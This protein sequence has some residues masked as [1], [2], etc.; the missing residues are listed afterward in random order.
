MQCHFLVS[1]GVE[2]PIENVRT[3]TV[4]SPQAPNSTTNWWR[5]YSIYPKLVGNNVKGSYSW[6]TLISF[7][8]S[9][10][11]ASKIWWLSRYFYKIFKW[12]T[13]FQF[14]TFFVIN[15]TQY[16]IS[17]PMDFDITRWP[18]LVYHER[19]TRWSFNTFAIDL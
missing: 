13:W 6:D 19:L 2:M 4:T 1:F 16:K 12:L 14:Q 5:K 11:M 7:M 18:L 9:A 10:K 3:T 15:I 8:G 17:I